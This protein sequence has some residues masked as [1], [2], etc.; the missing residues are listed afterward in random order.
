MPRSVARVLS[1]GKGS[2]DG[3]VDFDAVVVVLYSAK[4]AFV[5]ASTTL[6]GLDATRARREGRNVPWALF[7]RMC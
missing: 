7:G 4:A 6:G 3:S 1:A 5:V 2:D